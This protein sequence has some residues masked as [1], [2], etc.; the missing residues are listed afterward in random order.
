MSESEF[1]KRI[2][3]AQLIDTKENKKRYVALVSEPVF[4]AVRRKAFK[5]AL[6]PM[7]PNSLLKM[8]NLSLSA[9]Y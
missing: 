6:N 4:I 7:R 5:K 3:K 2:P 1:T 9:V 8:A